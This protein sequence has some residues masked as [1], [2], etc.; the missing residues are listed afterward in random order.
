MDIKNI[1]PDVSV[2]GQLSPADVGLQEL[3]AAALAYY[4]A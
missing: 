3:P 1:A 4:V 2:A